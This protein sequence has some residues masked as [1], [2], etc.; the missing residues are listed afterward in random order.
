MFPNWFARSAEFNFI[1]HLI[2]YADKPN[3]RYLQL[4]AYTG[5][6]TCWL[7]DHIL[8]D[9]SSTLT[10]VDTWRGS[11]EQEHEA[12]NFDAVLDY[13]LSRVARYPNLTTI[14][15]TTVDYLRTAPAEHFDFIY[16]DADHTTIGVVLDAELSWPA[17]KRGGIL[18]FDDLTWRET[19]E[20]EDLHPAPAIEM[21]KHRHRGE[22]EVL[23]ENTQLW[24]RK[25]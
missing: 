12:L 23:A 17:L 9:P 11:D 4:G 15:G 6:A 16:I 20:R 21:F 3:L 1:D 5:D 13:Y 7:L 19:W 2:S 10:D 8:T 14:R 18:A 24:I 25:T 22:F